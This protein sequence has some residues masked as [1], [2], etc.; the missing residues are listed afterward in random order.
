MADLVRGEVDIVGTDLTI[1]GERSQVIDF[2]VRYGQTS[3]RVM[4]KTQGRDTEWLTY[5]NG[6]VTTYVYG[7]GPNVHLA[8]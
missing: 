2:T 4:V 3:M 5:L 8:F 6:T 7:V 1:T